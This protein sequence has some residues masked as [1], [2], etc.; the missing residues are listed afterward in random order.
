MIDSY[1]VFPNGKERKCKYYD[2]EYLCQKII[3]DLISTDEQIKNK[4][5]EYKKNYTYFSPY[6]DF[7]LFEL[8]YKIKNPFNLENSI[9]YADKKM[10]CLE[11]NNLKTEIFTKSDDITIG[12]EKLDV[13]NLEK[14]MV[15][16]NLNAIKPQGMKWHLYISR[17]I[18]NH[19]FIQDAKL[20]KEYI[21]DCLPNMF[22]QYDYVQF[23]ISRKPFFSLDKNIIDEKQN[24]F[25][26]FKYSNCIYTIYA[27]E[28]TLTDLQQEFINTLISKKIIKPNFVA[29]VP[30]ERKKNI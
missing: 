25:S 24:Q 26:M 30:P 27:Y 17:F 29:I 20:Y 23:L 15:D 18:L 1:I 14:S 8:N 21:E 28:E 16:S 13:S 12:L 9:L 4:F 11:H 5:E 19:Y 10:I 7:L 6:F 2:I 3:N 22:Y